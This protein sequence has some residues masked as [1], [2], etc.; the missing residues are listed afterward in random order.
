MMQAAG[1]MILCGKAGSADPSRF[2]D[3]VCWLSVWLLLR[4]PVTSGSTTGN[5]PISL[6]V[7]SNL[8]RLQEVRNHGANS[9]LHFLLIS[10]SPSR[11]HSQISTLTKTVCGR[12]HVGGLYT[13]SLSEQSRGG[14]RCGGAEAGGGLL[15]GLQEPGMLIGK[16]VLIRP[17]SLRMLGETS[18]VGPHRQEG[19]SQPDIVSK[20]NGHNMKR[21]VQNSS[22]PS[23]WRDS[24]AC[25]MFASA[26]EEVA[27]I[28][29]M[30]VR[31]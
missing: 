21:A 1:G 12:I 5:E 31:Y 20:H 15:L 17:S 24:L 29:R 10:C 9:L 18:L 25:S 7:I 14:V 13:A 23:G 3:G 28:R 8:V 30:S 19:S 4:H 6:H 16:I 11:H 22:G 26:L 2:S 27:G